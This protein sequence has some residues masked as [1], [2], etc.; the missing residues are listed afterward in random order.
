MSSTRAPQVTT[1]DCIARDNRLAAQDN[2]LRTS[3]GGSSRYLISCI[4]ALMFVGVK[5]QNN[6]TRTVSMNSALE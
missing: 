6:A 3:Y 4:L 5:K 1:D 2:V